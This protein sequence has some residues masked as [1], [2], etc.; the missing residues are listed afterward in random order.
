[1]K[2]IN[3]KHFSSINSA[4][5]FPLINSKNLS[6]KR[7]R[8]EIFSNNSEDSSENKEMKKKQIR[9]LLQEKRVLC[10]IIGGPINRQKL[11]IISLFVNNR[12]LVRDVK[13]QLGKG[14]RVSVTLHEKDLL[15][16][17]C[18]RCKPVQPTTI[19]RALCR[20]KSSVEIN[21]EVPQYDSDDAPLRGKSC[22][23][24]VSFNLIIV[25]WRN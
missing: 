9:E 3:E 8:K 5:Q 13:D 15:K 19:Q 1:M 22:Y 20:S 7:D 12:K 16:K 14:K 2:K 6:I 10:N 17:N 25:V 4:G 24:K 18:T 11:K 23:C 21:F